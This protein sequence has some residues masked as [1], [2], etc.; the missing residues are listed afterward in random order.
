MNKK[1]WIL[2]SV[3]VVVSYAFRQSNLA[4]GNNFRIYIFVYF[5]TAHFFFIYLK[6]WKMVFLLCCYFQLTLWYINLYNNDC[7]CLE[8]EYCSALK[9]KITREQ[10]KGW[11]RNSSNRKR[12]ILLLK[13]FPEDCRKFSYYFIASGERNLWPFIINNIYS[14]MKILS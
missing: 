3:N 8:M 1:I 11:Q 4:E 9:R 5:F 6:L 14:S 10:K 13:Y 7:I 12:N 2:I